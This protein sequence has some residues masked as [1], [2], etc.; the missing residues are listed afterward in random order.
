MSVAE[1]PKR[2]K[3]DCPFDLKAIFEISLNQKGLKSV[4]E[5]ILDHLGKLDA[6]FASQE[7]LFAEL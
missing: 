2:F 1:K 5:F 4:L 3:I 6:R 7:G